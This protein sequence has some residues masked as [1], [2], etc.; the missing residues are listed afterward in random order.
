MPPACKCLTERG[1]ETERERESKRQRHNGVCE[2]SMCALLKLRLL[3]NCHVNPVTTS[4]VIST[5]CSVICVVTPYYSTMGSLLLN[6]HERTKLTYFIREIWIH[7]TELLFFFISCTFK[8]PWGQ[9]IFDR[10]IFQGLL[11][12]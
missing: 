11:L 4:H 9:L 3:F 5:Q 12:F 8:Q 2:G 7:S 1:R 6:W 10:S